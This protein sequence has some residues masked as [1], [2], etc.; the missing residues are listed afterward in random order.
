MNKHDLPI[1]KSHLPTFELHTGVR[2]LEGLVR[3]DYS[4]VDT[5]GLTDILEGL[6]GLLESVG[7]EEPV[8]SSYELIYSDGFIAVL[9]C[10]HSAISSILEAVDET[11]E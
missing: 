5:S 7:C 4:K 3:D 8:S 6:N 9:L 10:L 11:Q 1:S 2:I